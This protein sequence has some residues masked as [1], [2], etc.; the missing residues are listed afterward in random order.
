MASQSP[1]AESKRRKHSLDTKREQRQPRVPSR[2]YPLSQQAPVFETESILNTSNA[3]SPSPVKPTP[4]PPSRTQPRKAF[5]VG[6]SLAPTYAATPRKTDEIKSPSS[7]PSSTRAKGQTPLKLRPTQTSRPIPPLT[8][9]TE[10]A[11]RSPRL[12]TPSPA[13]GRQNSIISPSSSASSPPR[14]LAE[15]YQRI[16]DEENLA[17][18]E[19]REEM[20]GYADNPASLEPLPSDDDMGIAQFNESPTSLKASRRAS[21]PVMHENQRAKPSFRDIYE[22]LR[23]LENDTSLSVPQSARSDS[24]IQEDSQH[25]KDL[26]RMNGAVRSEPQI[27]RK[28]LVGKRAGLTVENLKRNNDSSD[29]LGSA[30]AA[31]ISS[32]GSDPSMN[33]PRQWGRKARPG[34]DWLS[35]INSKSGR[36]TGDVPKRRILDHP[37]LGFTEIRD[38][39]NKLAAAAAEVPLPSGDDVSLS[40]QSSTPTAAA[41]RAKSRDRVL[42][43]EPQ[44]QDFTGRSLQVSE[45]PPIR[46]RNATLDKILEKE[47]DTVAR[48]AVTTSRL[49]E[50]R[51]RSSAEQLGRRSPSLVSERGEPE[52]DQLT[53]EGVAKKQDSGGLPRRS[54]SEARKTPS[55][56]IEDLGPGDPVPDTP[57]V[58]YRSDSSSSRANDDSLTS[59]DTHRVSSQ[60]PKHGRQDSHS[61]LRKLARA[62]SASP[63]PSRN[64]KEDLEDADTVREE[65]QTG[66]EWS[67]HDRNNENNTQPPPSKSGDGDRATP[68]APRATAYLKTP[69]V[70]GAWV[71]TPLPTGGRGPPMPTPN[72]EDNEQKVLRSD[73]Q[74]L[75][76]GDLI[77]K[78]SPHTSQPKLPDEELKKTAPNLPRSAL[79]SIVNAAKSKARGGRRPHSPS[80]PEEYPT[81]LLGDSTIHSLEE[82]IVHDTDVSA[83]LQPSP[84]FSARGMTSS[85][86]NKSLQPSSRP[87]Y[88][89]DADAPLTESSQAGATD[90]RLYASQLSRLSALVP[91]LRETRKGLASLERTMSAPSFSPATSQAQ[92][93]IQQDPNSPFRQMDAKRE[94]Q[95]EGKEC[96]EAGEF[97]DFIWPCSRCGCPA[98]PLGQRRGYEYDIDLA[99]VSIP[100][101]RLWRW[102]HHHWRPHLTWP[103][104]AVFSLIFLYLAELWAQDCYCHKLFAATMVGY[105]VDINAPRPPFVLAKVI[106]RK[107]GMEL[108]VEVARFWSGV[109]GWIVGFAGGGGG[110]ARGRKPV[111]RD[112]RIP[113]P[114]WGPDLSMMNDEYL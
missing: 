69:M 91:S 92:S 78:L 3:Q 28:A 51:E 14:G 98:S 90:P 107:L 2:R 50:L 20:D 75:A 42:E 41:L 57:V 35:R 43:W 36:L 62:T 21:P 109:L 59:E 12:K 77:R 83:L 52:E 17:H 73:T 104:V 13:R 94:S 54:T 39:G 47:I 88:E 33:V 18:E 80:E 85:T 46:T 82:L 8:N 38:A 49:G 86:P 60:R 10:D 64:Q 76:T 102:R 96:T 6:R 70:T 16:V 29:S 72:L 95:D 37:N 97:H 111:S 5:S 4:R 87:E 53:A 67:N 103:G 1:E 22:N 40:S 23:D 25:A 65:N 56:A 66:H 63:S 31:S 7:R 24:P 79:E 108:L 44:D 11:N 114:E 105:G 101:P 45:S 100:I 106:W 68:Q 113:K 55:K 34:K 27:F 71:D 48:R 19:S 81:L 84:G 32:R 74:K 9:K 110:G 26:R 61:L 99:R 15:A 112:E 93:L 30:N 89:D 58:I